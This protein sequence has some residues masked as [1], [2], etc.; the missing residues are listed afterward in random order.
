MNKLDFI[1]FYF[2]FHIFQTKRVIQ[3]SVVPNTDLALGRLVEPF[4]LTDYVNPVCIPPVTWLPLFKQCFITGM[5]GNVLN[6]AFE[7]RVV[8]LCDIVD[9]NKYSFCTAQ[10]SNQEPFK[11]DLLCVFFYSPDQHHK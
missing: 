8:G 7:T 2:I 9:V 3:F 10:V 1:S 5:Q 11:C 6:H 4:D